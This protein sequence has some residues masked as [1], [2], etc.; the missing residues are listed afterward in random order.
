MDLT[1]LPILVEHPRCPFCHDAIGPADE[2]TPCL[3]C[4]AWQHTDCAAEGVGRCGACR[5][6][7]DRP[8]IRATVSRRDVARAARAQAWSIALWVAA[9]AA[10][11]AVHGTILPAFHIMFREVGCSLPP[12]T[13]WTLGAGKWIW[14]GLVLTLL[15]GAPLLRDPVWRSRCEAGAVATF[16]VG[17]AIGVVGLF[18]PLT[19]LDQKL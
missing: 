17:G 11:L 19:E 9:W 12:L 3:T 16:F 5:A 4:R 18:A 1:R 15:H 13:A 2:A 8:P 7:A 10:I 6:L 14:A